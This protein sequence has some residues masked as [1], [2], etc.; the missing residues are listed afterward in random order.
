M[1]LKNTFAP[2]P[3]RDKDNKKQTDETDVELH[4]TV[5]HRHSLQH[6]SS[7]SPVETSNEEDSSVNNSENIEFDALEELPADTMFLPDLPMDKSNPT[8]RG[9]SPIT[10]AG[11][12]GGFLRTY[13]TI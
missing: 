12:S 13:K 6:H 11:S 8:S 5:G 2:P 1:K 4:P 7:L 3:E 10:T 9:T